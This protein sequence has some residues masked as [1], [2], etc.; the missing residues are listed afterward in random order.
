MPQ[1][2]LRNIVCSERWEEERLCTRE[3]VNLPKLSTTTQAR[4]AV[5]EFPHQLG[6][7]VGRNPQAG[8][9][10][11]ASVLHP[12]WGMSRIYFVLRKS[13]IVGKIKKE[14]KGDSHEHISNHTSALPS[15]SGCPIRNTSPGR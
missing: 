14:K 15:P 6:K 3:R 5:G 4:N 8:A 10:K 12:R 7:F 2:G 1:A 13:Y 11:D 9:G